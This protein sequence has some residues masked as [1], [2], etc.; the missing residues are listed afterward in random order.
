M[1]GGR[2]GG[3]KE[4]VDAAEHSQIISLLPLTPRRPFIIK[5]F[6]SLSRRTGDVLQGMKKDSS[7]SGFKSQ[8]LVLEAAQSIGGCSPSA[9]LER[10]WDL[11]QPT[12]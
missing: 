11:I 8:F 7:Y 3:G 5:A 4:A 1:E 10:C 6:G 12:Y 9:G 2:D